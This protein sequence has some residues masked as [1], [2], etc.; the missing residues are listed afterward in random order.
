MLE[1][2]QHEAYDHTVWVVRPTRSLT[3]QEA[4]RWLCLISLIPLASGGLFL[5]FGAPFVLPFAGLEIALLWAAFYYVQWQG[6]WR[7][8]IDLSTRALVIE[9]GRHEPTQREEFD[10][11]WVRVELEQ[12]GR[13]RSSS[14][15]LRSHGRFTELGSFLTDGERQSLAKALINALK[16]SR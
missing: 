6:Q 8:V 1:T 5:W 16:K 14:L 4:K 3:W 15:L 11:A 9:R 2:L 13:W 10:P 12:R 7:E